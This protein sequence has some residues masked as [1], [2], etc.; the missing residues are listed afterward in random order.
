MSL[1]LTFQDLLD[2]RLRFSAE[3]LHRKISKNP[4]ENNTAG[5]FL[6][7]FVGYRPAVLIKTTPA[8]VLSCEFYEFI[9]A[10]GKLLRLDKITE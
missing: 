9:F 3:K 7:E 2:G 8:H 1:L 5:V 6:D 10:A 4:Q